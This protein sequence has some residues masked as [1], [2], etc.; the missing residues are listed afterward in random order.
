MLQMQLQMQQQLQMQPQLTL[1]T[2]SDH[3][4]PMSMR[5]LADVQGRRQNHG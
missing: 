5:E 4:E 3:Q 1:S 2:E